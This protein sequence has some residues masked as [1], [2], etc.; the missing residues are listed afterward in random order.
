MLEGL[1][2]VDWPA[3]DGAYGPATDTPDIL[4]AMADP[5]PETAREGQHEFASSVWHQGSVYPV[6]V[7]AVPFLV[8]LATTPGVR[9]RDGLLITLG[10][11][12]DP[13]HSRGDDL[14]AVQ[15]AIAAR[16]AALVPQ[17]ADPDPE[18]RAGAAY[19]LGRCGAGALEALRDRWTVESDE[20]VRAALLLGI[21]HH[22]G[23]TC[24]ELLRAAAA[25]GAGPVPA[26]AAL[27]HAKAGLPLPP[28]IVAAV[29]ASF[30]AHDWRTPWAEGGALNETLQRLDAGSADALAAAMLAGGG[31]ADGR[32]RLAWSLQSRFRAKRSAPVALLPRLRTLLND[33][34]DKVVAAA[35]DAA[36]HA[37]TAAS[38]VAGELA[39]IAAGGLAADATPAA[40]MP[41]RHVNGGLT[42]YPEPANTALAV[43]VRLGDRRWRDV[44][45]PAWEAGHWTSADGLL[46]RYVP[47]FDP[48]A[49]GG[50]RRRITA[51]L[52]A[53]VPGNPI[54]EAVMTL[55]GWGPA[56][57]PAVPELIAALPAA[58]AAVPLALAA[59]GPAAREALPALRKAGDT[60]AG[61]AI[62]RLTGD[63]EPLVTAA[64]A[65]L[66][67][68]PPYRMDYELRLVADT[69]PAAAPLVPRLRPA[70][71][72]TADRTA[73]ERA[74]QMAVARL[75]WRA[76]GDAAAVLPTVAAVLPAGDASARPAA[77]LAAD[78]APAAGGL[79]PLLRDALANSW[80]RVDAARALWRHGVD[81]AELIDALL[82]AAADPGGDSGAVALLVEMGATAAVPGLIELA[83]RDERVVRHGTWTDTVWADDTLRRNLWAAV[84]TLS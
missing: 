5:D 37:G 35:V 27:A 28:E 38:A 20:A 43:L 58:T 21:A 56:A 25:G 49:L 44:A 48:V 80:A 8:E 2:A 34:H 32:V 53:R 50:V 82:T 7:V 17:L 29:A 73:S 9:H 39:R 23:A 69:G 60:R 75:V 12:T 24:A 41:F 66:E 36:V 13:E 71:T 63:P 67:R 6:T 83:E 64:A 10:M 33:P 18:V 61:H 3:F 15:Q 11:L 47:Q 4:R 65:M 68:T 55:V 70:L 72:G 22:D 76:T 57:A 81:P 31:A 19:A 52:A 77:A 79:R 62:W 42:G 59:I 14:P 51:L 54:I 84:T 46:D 78:L 45:L 30:A 74:A 16:G 26:A 1:D 40:T